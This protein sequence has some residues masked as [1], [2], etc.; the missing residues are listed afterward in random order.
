MIQEHRWGADHLS[1]IRRV[2]T[3]HDENG[4]AVF[5][6]DTE[7]D[8][9]G[10]I[11]AALWTHD[12]TPRF[13]SDGSIPDPTSY[14]PRTGGVRFYIATLRSGLNAS[15]NDAGVG[16]DIAALMAL[17]PDL[18][19]KAASADSSGFHTDDCVTL[20]L[21]LSGKVTLELDD[22]AQTVLVPGDVLV[23]NGTRHRWI[24]DDDEP[25]TIAMVMI[26]AA[27]P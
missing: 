17:Y 18:V 13:P 1:S 25:A 11:G 6:S 27:V 22:G 2:V 12:E 9:S 5:A 4:K 14:W 3:G 7:V 23:Q 15:A 21:V 20:H 8:A 19:E 16:A 10:P 26:G 24:G